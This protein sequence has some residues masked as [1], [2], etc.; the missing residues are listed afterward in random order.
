M[1]NKPIV[2]LSHAE[3]ME[4]LKCELHNRELMNDVKDD[5][6]RCF[7]NPDEIQLRQLV[8][9]AIEESHL[10][11]KAIMKYNYEKFIK[12]EVE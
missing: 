3:R 8:I 4:F 1:P 6:I 11:Q 2:R 12:G 7:K 5:H 9:Q 10:K